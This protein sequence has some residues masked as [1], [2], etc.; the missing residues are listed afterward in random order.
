MSN[1]RKCSYE[2]PDLFVG[3][4]RITDVPSAG[5]LEPRYRAE[6]NLRRVSSLASTTQ[7]HTLC[8]LNYRSLFLKF[9]EAGKST[10]KM[11]ADSLPDG[12]PFPSW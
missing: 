12:D 8:G 4:L 5:Q 6:G 11:P 7:P 3:K 9:L 10:I 2:Y 1:R